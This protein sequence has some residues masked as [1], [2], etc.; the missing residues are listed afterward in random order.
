MRRLLALVGLCLAGMAVA[1]S[2]P[3]NQP[4]PVFEGVSGVAA[5]DVGLLTP[6]AAS[7]IC[8]RGTWSAQAW[9]AATTA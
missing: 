7:S 8:T 1:A 6:P 5:I 4:L 2:P 3:V 9:G